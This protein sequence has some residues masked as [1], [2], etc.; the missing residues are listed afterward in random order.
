MTP[1]CR[2]LKLTLIP[3]EPGCGCRIPGTTDP[4]TFLSPDDGALLA[5]RRLQPDRDAA[6]RGCVSPRVV[7]HKETRG[8]AMCA[9]ALWDV[10]M[11]RGDTKHGQQA[12]CA[13]SFRASPP[14]FYYLLE[15]KRQ[16]MYITPG[17]RRNSGHN[18]IRGGGR[19]SFPTP[20]SDRPPVFWCAV[21]PLP[22]GVLQREPGRRHMWADLQQSVSTR[23]RSQDHVVEVSVGL[24]QHEEPEAALRCR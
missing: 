16:Y 2:A 5:A 4:T 20:A 15:D 22:A 17:G 14:S 24:Q 11:Q 7:P 9:K 1:R 19:R 3:P 23:R 8:S 18:V 21:Q 10:A 13:A 12:D 6:C